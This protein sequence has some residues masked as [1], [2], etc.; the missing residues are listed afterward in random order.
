[1]T[2]VVL[3]V[4]FGLASVASVGAIS[5]IRNSGRDTDTQRALAAA[6]AGVEQAQLRQNKIRTADGFPCLVLGANGDLIPGSALP[7]GWCPEL[8]DAVD[9][10]NF[11]YTVSPASAAGVGKE[12]ITIISEGVAGDSRRRIAVDSLTSTGAP[13][14]VDAT[15]AGR[16]SLTLDG[17]ALIDATAG[18]NGDVILE[19]FAEICGDVTH[20]VGKTL[21]T[22]G[23]DAGVCPE[24]TIGE[25]PLRLAPPDPGNVANENDNGRFFGE[26]VRT[27]N[28]GNV[29]WDAASRTLKLSG[30][31]TLTLGGSNYSL[32]KL[33]MTGNSRIYIAAGARV[34]IWFDS[35]EACGQPS[36]VAQLSM[37]GTSQ[38]STTSGVPADGGLIFVGSASIPTTIDLRGDGTANELIVYA[39]RSDVNVGGEGNYAGAIAGKTIAVF[40]SG[41][42]VGD[43]SALDF[44]IP[45]QTAYTPERFIECV[46][47][48]TTTPDD[49]C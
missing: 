29:T 40:G 28:A 47:P 24:Y 10:N 17:D 37:A 4:G 12:R 42:I 20:G 35:P 27:G 1:M 7:N 26:D 3:T 19:G 49:G 18:T 36:G 23:A 2:L 5:S 13:A 6:E 46:G 32:C 9:G 22:V 30:E 34:R 33:E 44:N 8:S 39:P 11:T 14:F 41:T 31:G 15:V 48:L 16:D 25:Q 38:I 21:I 43:D 45:V